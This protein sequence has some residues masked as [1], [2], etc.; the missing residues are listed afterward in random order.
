MAAVD[1]RRTLAEAVINRP[2]EGEKKSESKKFD[3][4][5]L[6]DFDYDLRGK[7]GR[8]LKHVQRV[9][10]DRFTH[11]CKS[12]SHTFN[13]DIRFSLSND[14]RAL[15]FIRN[16]WVHRAG[17]VDQKIAEDWEEKPR[18]T[19]IPLPPRDTEFVLDGALVKRLMDAASLS[20]E[21]LV[22]FTDD[23]LAKCSA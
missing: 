18:I 1:A 14:I 23:K 9:R 12:Y 6:Q 22:K 15:E 7:W 4:A 5:S 2:Q 16:L 19:G 13:E 11:I 17:Y 3:L 21:E 10:F 8:F 20:A